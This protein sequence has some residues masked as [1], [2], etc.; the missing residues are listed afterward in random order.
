[1]VQKGLPQIST[2]VYIL[3]I[4]AGIMGRYTLSGVILLKE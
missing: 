2:Y 4:V 3:P 1:M